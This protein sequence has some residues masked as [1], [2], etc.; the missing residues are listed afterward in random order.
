[1]GWAQPQEPGSFTVTQD[2]YDLL[3]KIR[4]GTVLVVGAT[5]GAGLI[6]AERA[7]QVTDEG[8]RS[9]HDE[10]WTDGELVRAAYCYAA[11]AID[12]RLATPEMPPPGWPH[13]WDEA[14]WKPADSST[15]N[16]EKAGAL[17]AAEIDRRKAA[18]ADG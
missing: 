12:P 10:A 8:F 11:A 16:M 4:A 14:W 6:V 3:D 7:R 2:E 1:M 9:D 17:I 15:R 13:G 18:E 5:S